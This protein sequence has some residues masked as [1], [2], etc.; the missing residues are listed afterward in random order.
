MKTVTLSRAHHTSRW[1]KTSLYYLIWLLILTVV[2]A[3]LWLLQ[4]K[5]GT[6]SDQYSGAQF[7][8][9]GQWSE[10]D[11]APYRDAYLPAVQSQHRI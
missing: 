6:R 5:P 2:F 4:N 7:V 3:V 10:D 11:G 9:A 8:L 1:I